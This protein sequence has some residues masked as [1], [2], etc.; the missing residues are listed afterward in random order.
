MLLNLLS[1]LL[2]TSAVA[3]RSLEV[4][5]TAPEAVYANFPSYGPSSDI[6]GVL[7]FENKG[8]AGVQISS[9]G[10]TELHSFPAELGPFL[11][12]STTLI[13]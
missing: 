12:H 9:S 7:V 8:S 13:A 6:T 5:D 1:S 11:Y 10:S 4:R 3:A 2:L